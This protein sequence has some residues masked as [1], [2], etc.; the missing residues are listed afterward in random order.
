M[1]GLNLLISTTTFAFPYDEPLPLCRKL[2]KEEFSVVHCV[3]QDRGQYCAAVSNALAVLRRGAIMT[4]IGKRF[5]EA[6][7][8]I[9]NMLLLDGQM[10]QKAV[11]DAAMVPNGEAREALY[12]LLN[13]G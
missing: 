6:A 7:K 8:R 5:S 3:S 4:V 13:D 1:N 12:A 2:S 10:E 11:A 9:W